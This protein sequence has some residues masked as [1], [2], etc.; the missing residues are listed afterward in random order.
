M[1]K[2]FGEGKLLGRE[3]T[4]WIAAFTAV[5][6]VL[7]GFRLDWL[8]PE[9]AA[10]IGAFLNA[11][12][13][14]WVAFKTKPVAPN[15]F[16]Y[17][18]SVL[19]GLLSAYGLNFTQEQVSS[20]Q[21]LVLMMFVLISRGQVSPIEDA[22]QTGVLGDKVTTEDVPEEVVEEIQ[23]EIPALDT[24]PPAKISWPRKDN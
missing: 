23:Q 1:M 2:I 8:S 6:N 20:T 21:G 10:W 17:A 22:K 11:G 18:V 7:V 19:A 5:L 12:G 16:S 3:P 13:A 14:V 15:V 24:A 4:L 9:Q